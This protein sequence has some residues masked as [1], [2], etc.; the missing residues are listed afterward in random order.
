MAGLRVRVSTPPR[1]SRRPSAIGPSRQTT[2]AAGGH[3]KPVPSHSPRG[4]HTSTATRDAG[5][6]DKPVPFPHPS[7]PHTSNSDH[8]GCKKGRI[9]QYPSRIP[10]GPTTIGS[11]E[12][13]NRP[14]PAPP[15]DG[16]Y[17]GCDAFGNQYF[18]NPYYFLG[19]SRWVEYSKSVKLEYDATQITP[20]WFGWLHYRTDRL[21]DQDCPKFLLKS[22]CKSQ[23]WLLNHEENLS[24]TPSA[25][26][27]YDTTRRRIDPW[28][29]V[30]KDNKKYKEY[31]SLAENVIYCGL[32]AE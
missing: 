6:Q 7:R 8:E 1:P 31:M 32:I 21:P 28:D 9:N 3:D 22:C 20:E 5:G 24:G 19:R 29:A 2:R 11:T 16:R 14:P 25:Y 13:D 10:R 27:P 4:L 26:Y 30:F 18:E 17:V 23:C 15:P 12:A